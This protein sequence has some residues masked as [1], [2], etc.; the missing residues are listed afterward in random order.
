M[1]IKKLTLGLGLLMA[2]AVTVQAETYKVRSGDTISE[3]AS[4]FHVKTNALLRANGLTPSSRLKLGRALT[5][6]SAS[7]YTD[8]RSSRQ[9]PGRAGSYVVRNGDHDWSIATKHGVTPTQLRNLNPGIDWRALQIGQ[10]IRVPGSGAAPTRTAKATRVEKISSTGS[11]KVREGDND[12]IIAR[13]LDTQPSVLRRLNPGLNWSRVQIG[14]TIR[15]PGGRSSAPAAVAVQANRIRSRYAVVAREDATIRRNPSTRAE[16]V[17]TVPAGIRVTVLD[18]DGDW[19]R[20]RFPKGTEGWMRGDMLKA[21][22]APRDVV[23]ASRKARKSQPKAQRQYVAKRT[24]KAST[25]RRA[26][27]SKHEFTQEATYAMAVSGDTQDKIL[28]KARSMR[29]V[30]YRWGASSRSATDCSG[31]TSQVFGSNGYRLPRTSAAQSKT[32]AKVDRNS[33]KPGDLVFFKTRRGTRVSHVGIYTGNG[34]FIHASSGGGK[35]QVNS[36]SDGYYNKRFVTARRV[37]KSSK[38]TV[39]K[40]PVKKAEEPVALAPAN[41]A[42][43]TIQSTDTGE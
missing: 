10:R 39:K 13:R 43:P 33:L 3:I 29:G 4:R 24:P 16:A 2:G 9:V 1:P 37:V 40:A 26:T 34:K 31:F 5:I 8:R 36:L 6:P 35:V 27:E 21:G 23:V 7:V 22:S 25:R 15:V 18:R 28:S 20:L 12:W 17:T 41:E 38:K 11:Y 19:Y 14:Q 30:R 32:G 42:T